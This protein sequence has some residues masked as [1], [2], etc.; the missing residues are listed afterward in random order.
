MLQESAASHAVTK[1][2][3]RKSIIRASVC[4]V[5]LGGSV[6]VI[7]FLQMLS[8]IIYPFSEK[9]FSSANAGLAGMWWTWCTY[10]LENVNGARMHYTGLNLP[11]GERA[12]VICN[13]QSMADIPIIL[14]LAR[15]KG[16][17]SAL[18]WFVKDMLKFVPGIGWGMLFLGCPF[19]KRNWTD[20]KALIEST[21]HKITRLGLP[22]WLVS[23][24]EGTRFQPLKLAQSQK[25]AAE[26]GLPKL[27]WLLT[28]RTKGFV[29]SVQ[30]LRLNIDAIYDLTIGYP[31]EVNSLLTLAQSVDQDFHVDVKRFPIAELPTEPHALEKWVHER[32]VEKD[33]LLEGFHKAGDFSDKVS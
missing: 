18:K 32:F 5:A 22:V 17:I 13:H 29:A 15:R 9:K 8:L 20:D 30:G 27:N 33:L 6:I 16:R 24:V 3:A 7:N 11:M 23:F 4:A 12:I 28:P 31:P 21:F 14:S 25:F 2:P 19:V 26:K 10:F 1:K